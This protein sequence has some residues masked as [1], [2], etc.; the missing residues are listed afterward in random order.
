MSEAGMEDSFTP[1]NVVTELMTEFD[2]PWFVSGGW[3][4][5]LFLGRVTREHADIEIGIFRRDQK[6]IRDYLGGWTFEKADNGKW[7]AWAEEEELCLPIHQLKVR[8]AGEPRGEF[9]FFLNER[10]DRHWRSRRHAGLERPLEEVWTNSFLGIPILAPEIQLLFKA[11][12]TRGKDQADFENA[13]QRLSSEQRRWLA[14]GLRQ[15]HPEHVWL[16]DLEQI[17]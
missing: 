3:A 5:D 10:S 6:A 14:N 8:R 2:R 7:V 11:K 1:I 9:E 13:V 12:E 4:I 17:D 16:K 15:N